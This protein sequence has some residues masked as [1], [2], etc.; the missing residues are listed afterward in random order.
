MGAFGLPGPTWARRSEA[1]RLT[2]RGRLRP[3]CQAPR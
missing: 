3:V 2:R 1:L